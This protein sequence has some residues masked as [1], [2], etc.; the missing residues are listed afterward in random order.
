MFW[1]CL[2]LGLKPPPTPHLWGL[3][4]SSLWLQQAALSPRSASHL[5]HKR[6]WVQPLPGV[7]HWSQG[8][9]PSA[10]WIPFH[11]RRGDRDRDSNVHFHRN[12]PGKRR[13]TGLCLERRT[14]FCLEWSLRR[15]S[16]WK[17]VPSSTEQGFPVAS[18]LVI[19]GVTFKFAFASSMW[20]SEHGMAPRERT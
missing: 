6:R 1:K 2:G 14:T 7:I 3:F 11:R 9:C 13:L 20:V 4:F 12:A 19:S 17:R 15:C 10:E 18:S 8:A 16:W 5:I